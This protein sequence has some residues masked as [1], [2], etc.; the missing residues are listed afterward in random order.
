MGLA[1]LLL[2]KDNP[3]AQWSGQN[4]NLLGA[5]S[6]GLAQGPTFGRGVANGLAMAPQAKMLDMQAADKLKEKALRD[7]QQNATKA[8]LTKEA[9][10]LAQLLDTGIPMGEVW[11]EYLRR[12][13]PGGGL[14]PTANMQDWNFGQQNPGYWDALHP[15]QSGGGKLPTSYE[16]YLLA[17]ENPG[18][19]ATLSSS[20]SKPPTDAQR[21]ATQLTAVV[22]PDAKLLLGDETSPGV[23]ESMADAGNQTAGGLDINGWKPLRGFTDP[24]YQQATNALT[25]IAQS[26]LYAISGQAA[27]AAEVA[28][29]VESVTPKMGESEQSVR[30]KKARLKSYVDA[31]ALGQKNGGEGGGTD[32][33]DAILT[34]LG[35]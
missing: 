22:A 34:G 21:R 7:Q 4:Q 26:Y 14:D 27:P 30:D 15:G 8:L 17:Q 18:Y 13:K 6:A 3:L 31:I 29:I 32:D 5:L 28:K 20:T 11:G 19:A 35:I 33:V 1:E 9:P 10:D 24:K 25:N 16:E 2:G 23:F 12:K